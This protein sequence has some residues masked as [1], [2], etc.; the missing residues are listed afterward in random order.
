MAKPRIDEAMS[1]MQKEDWYNAARDLTYVIENLRYTNFDIL[2][3]EA[4]LM[5][6]KSTTKLQ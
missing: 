1:K 5:Q 4:L 6:C 2:L 3:H